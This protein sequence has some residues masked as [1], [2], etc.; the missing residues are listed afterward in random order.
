M[1]SF[2]RRETFI[3]SDPQFDLCMI[4]RGVICQVFVWFVH[5]GICKGNTHFF[6]YKKV[7]LDW[8]KPQESSSPNSKKLRKCKKFFT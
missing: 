3:R 2:L 6:I 7:V 4:E 1:T 5:V 8:P